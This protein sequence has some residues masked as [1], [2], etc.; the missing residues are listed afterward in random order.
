MWEDAGKMTFTVERDH[1]SAAA[2]SVS[3]RI[4]SGASAVGGTSCNDDGVDFLWP[5]GSSAGTGTVT[6]APTAQ[7]ATLEVTVCDDTET[8]GK[9]NLVLELT[10]KSSRNPTAIGT[11][12][13]ND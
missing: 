4:V 8:E 5:S 12:L 6:M 10:G 13:D 7:T 3:Y 1:T 9:E 11:I 2:A